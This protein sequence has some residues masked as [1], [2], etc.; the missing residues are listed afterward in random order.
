MSLAFEPVLAPPN[1]TVRRLEP[2]DAAGVVACVREIYG[3]SYVHPELYRP[4]EIARLN[5]THELVSVVALDELGQ[6]VGHYALERPGLGPL[7]E[8]G[9]ALVLPAHRHHQLMEQMRDV[10]EREASRLNLTALFGNVVTNHVF[11]QRVVERFAEA[12]LAV[13]FGWSPASFHNLPEPLP[14]RMS[15]LLYYK[16]LKRPGEA[17]VH[18]P[19]RHAAWCRRLYAQ[20]EVSLAERPGSAPPRG[21]VSIE[22][23]ERPDLGRAALRVRGAVEG[24]AAAVVNERERLAAAGCEAVFVELPL[25]QPST[26]GL[27]EELESAGFFYSGIAPHFAADGDALRLQWQRDPLD[28]ALLKVENP[29]ARELVSYAIAERARAKGIGAA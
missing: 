16:Y 11:S 13:S 18:L 9:E 5:E 3:G 2:A 15:T 7:A 26:P 19:P 8:T 27:C 20:L 23:Q 25:A 12:P 10:L 4:S 17:V 21:P 28:P 1:Y 22:C 6:V 14:Q 24:A 29:L